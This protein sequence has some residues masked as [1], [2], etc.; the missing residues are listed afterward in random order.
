LPSFD[1]SAAPRKPLKTSRVIPL[2]VVCALGAIAFTCGGGFI[3]YTNTQHLVASRN[4]LDHS[5]SVLSSLQAESQRL[6]RVGY[7]TRLYA[8]TADEDELRAA[9][10]ALVAMRVGVLNLENLVRDNPAQ[11]LQVKMLDTK[12]QHLSHALENAKALRQIP[13]HEVQECRQSISV[14][15]EEERDLLTQ[16]SD[17]SENSRDR[18]LLSGVGF[19][20]FSLVVV[21]VLFGFLLRDALRRRVFEEDISM[22]NDRLEATIEELERR[23]HE[24]ILLKTA[25]DQLQLCVT[26]QEAQE[27]VARYFARL[28]PGSSG[29]TLIINN[30]RSMLEIVAKWNDPTS[31]ADSFEMEACCGLRVGRSRW[32][33][34]GQSELHCSHFTGAA[35]ENYVCIPLAAQGDTLGF[36]YLSCPT[37]EITDL[38]YSRME[39]VQE[40]VELASMAIAGLNLR[41]K[42]QSQS[43]RDGLTNLFNRHFMEIALE[44][45]LQRAARRHVSLAVLMLDVDHFKAFNDTFG[46]E[47][48]D[49]VLRGV[50]ECMQQ[51]VRSEDVV[52]RYGGEEF[53]IILPEI[54]RELALE[55][56]D[57]IRRS[58]GNLR[59]KYRGEAL[60]QISISVGLTMYPEPAR[61]AADLLRMADQALYEAKHAGRDRIHV[62]GSNSLHDQV[63]QLPANPLYD[64]LLNPVPSNAS[65]GLA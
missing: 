62:A 65:S 36:V 55:R 59:V 24:G 15:Q 50:A 54:S 12:V 53:V 60:R 4:W 57:A 56:A 23:S 33:R 6:D 41:A 49:V 8:A 42:L 19:L 27:C 25:R 35:P 14:I 37:N 52:C 16:R 64:E 13:E 11:T 26:S 40:M 32:R 10:A 51:A 48:G 38:A 58:V 28:V 20:G 30:S 22:A 17:D 61:D 43:I 9:E 1:S 18:S 45:E 3:V 5:Q 39:L 31:L 63:E 7:D 21:I 44:R 47:A 34:L 46:H 2:L 29:A